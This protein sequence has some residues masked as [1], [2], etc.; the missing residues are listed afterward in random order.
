MAISKIY[1]AQ[2]IGL[3]SFIITIETDLSN[4]LHSFSIVGLPDKAVEEAKDRI[5]S[6][7]KNSGYVSPKQK[8]QKV[9]ISL[10]P[11]DIRK[12]GTAFD[13]GMALGYLC[14]SGDIDFDPEDKIF[15][16]ELSLG[17]KIRKI[18]G[19]LPIVKNAKDK[20]FK[21]I[22][23]PKENVI[24]ASLIDGIKIFG[25]DDLNSV[26]Y[27]IKNLQGFRI[28]N[29]KKT[30]INYPENDCQIDFSQVQGQNTAK[31]GLLISA[32]GGHN[33]AMYGPPG[34]GKTMLAKA[35]IGILPQLT[36]DEIL[37]VT[38]IYS[39]SK[40]LDKAFI[41]NPPF[42][43][44][45][46]TSSYASLVGGGNF[47]QPGEI[48]LSH[49]GVLFLDEFIEFERS[50]IDALRQPLEDGLITISRAKGKITFPAK[51][52]LLASMNPCPCGYAGNKGCTCTVKELQQYKKKLSGP[53]IDRIDIWSSV[54]KVEYDNLANP[55]KNNV[56]S[57]EMRE[58]VK[59]VRKIQIDR[60]RKFGI[61][62]KSL[63]SDMSVQDINTI[64]KLNSNVKNLLSKSAERLNM[65][66][67]A[68]HRTLKVARTI[69]DL[70]YKPDINE[71]HILEAL[72]YRQRDF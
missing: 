65:S 64:I 25:V 52:I 14:A 28:K 1:S 68:Y 23:L 59:K 29:S 67:R 12:E 15:L 62:N 31:R 6:A 47:P 38:S 44:P 37:E 19:V 72:Q 34:T 33:M 27:H 58:L 18:N 10:A 48:T 24:E 32:S 41:V 11:A 69:A 9:V 42:R 16:G 61:K 21:E 43:A 30:K 20:G 50:V 60:Y 45:H 57:K 55:D 2:L 17:G 56:T 71:E 66:G 13:L 63:N 46:H 53:I 51:C 5:S 54:H 35:F 26:I 36:K 49:R 70:E 39:V 22:Y 40:L 3:D 7:I 8:N 4:G